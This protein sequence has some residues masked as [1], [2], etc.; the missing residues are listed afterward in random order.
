MAAC[1]AMG[2]AAG[3]AAKQA[4][5]RNV[6]PADVGQYQPN[7]PQILIGD[8]NSRASSN[9]FDSVRAAGFVDS[10]AALYGETD[11]GVTAHGFEPVD[12]PKLTEKGKIDFNFCK[13]NCKLLTA[14]IIKDKPKGIFPSDHFF[15]S[16]EIIL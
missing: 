10:Y 13:G 6:Q 11:P 15:V 4:V 5:R 8:F 16:A 12:S 3:R 7:F 14:G 1:L 9:G 2:E